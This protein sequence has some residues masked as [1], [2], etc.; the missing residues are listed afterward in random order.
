MVAK[1]I[2]IGDATYTPGQM[3]GPLSEAGYSLSIDK[4][5][6]DFLPS[7][8][9]DIATLI[10]VGVHFGTPKLYESYPKA[11]M[12]LVEPLPE[13]RK[14]V[15]KRY[16]PIY[17]IDFIHCAAGETEDTLELHLTG[18]GSSLLEKHGLENDQRYKGKLSVPVRRLDD[19]MKPYA[20]PFGL[21]ID[22]EGFELSVLKGA[23]ETLKQTQFVIAEVSVRP[24]FKGSYSFA[25]IVSWLDLHGFKF[26]AVLND[27]PG[28][29]AF[30]DCMFV[31]AD[32]HLVKAPA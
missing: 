24:R 6:A 15:D 22:V 32:S 18:S 2:T 14:A 30:F 21:K 16:S 23:V 26:L 28:I 7:L 9:L 4:F 20:G 1:S 19:I 27:G 11:K 12:V 31:R 13:A 29:N 5:S 10:D 3:K 25:E 8:N 17:D